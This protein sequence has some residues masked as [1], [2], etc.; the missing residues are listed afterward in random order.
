MAGHSKWANI[1]HRKGRQDAIRGRAFTKIAKELT[2]AARMGGGDPNFNPRLR[3][4]LDKAKGSNMPKDNIERAI[5][6]GTGELEGV[7]YMEIRYEGYGPE[8]VAV[9]VD[10]LTDNK[11][12]SA[13]SVRSI[14]SKNGGNLGETGAVGWMFDRKGVMNFSKENISE[15]KLMEIALE[16]GAEDIKDEGDTLVVY[17]DPSEFENVRKILEEENKLK[18]ESSEITFV[19]QNTVKITDEEKAAAIIK[20]YEKLEE[21]DDVQDVYANFEIDD[22]IMEKLM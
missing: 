10:V 7:E 12:R 8:G 14:F 11:N 2:V 9:I 17:T 1:Q 4:A 5:K 22:D 21:D 3:L 19:P 13:A 16:A 20:L 18:I 6:K 15:E